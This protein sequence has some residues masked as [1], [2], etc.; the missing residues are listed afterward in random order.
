MN[1][2]FAKVVGADVRLPH[3]LLAMTRPSG[4][5]MNDACHYNMLRAAQR[6]A[7]VALRLATLLLDIVDEASYETMH[8]VL[9]ETPEGLLHLLL[10]HRRFGVPTP[11]SC[12]PAV[13]RA[14]LAANLIPK[15]G[16]RVG[17]VTMKEYTEVRPPACMP[18]CVRMYVREV[19]RHG[20]QGLSLIP[21]A[22]YFVVFAAHTK[23][24][25]KQHAELIL[26]RIVQT[27][28]CEPSAKSTWRPKL[29]QNLQEWL[30]PEGCK[31]WLRPYG[32]IR[33]DALW[34]ERQVRL[35]RMHVW[36]LH[37][38]A[39]MCKLG[40]IA[41]TLHIASTYFLGSYKRAARTSEQSETGT[42]VR[43]SQNRSRPA[44]YSHLRS[45]PRD[46]DSTRAGD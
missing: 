24:C 42:R 32:S 45:S 16:N 4:K 13:V 40:S 12:V 35:C 9:D 14:E 37:H 44:P 8:A 7:T 28:L 31:V 19:W 11:T 18:K 25:R 34:V 17:G 29:M 20:T 5:I 6:I 39:T 46:A 26:Q 30:G 33:L 27:G 41:S 3:D 43:E 2:A 22:L 36:I 38:I 15:T 21:A 1:A 10:T 23:I